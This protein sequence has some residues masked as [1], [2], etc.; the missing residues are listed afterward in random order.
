MKACALDYGTV[1][2][3]VAVS[4][5]LGLYAHPRAVISARNTGLMLQAIEDLVREDAITHIVV[6]L[7]LD[8]KGG[9]GSSAIAARAFATKVANATNLTVELWDERLSTA[10]ANR[11]LKDQFSAKKSRQRIDSAAACVILQSWLEARGNP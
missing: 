9:E 1:R 2:V 8:M 4:D 7:P 5:E 10:Q 3:G 6:G 11:S